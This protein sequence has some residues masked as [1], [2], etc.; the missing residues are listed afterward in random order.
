[1][2]IK[3]SVVLDTNILVSALV[4]GGNPEEILKLALTKKI[5]AVTSLFLLAELTEILSKKFS[6]DEKKTLLVVRKIKNT[7]QVVY[8]K[9]EI[10]V[11]KD[12]NPDNRVLEAAFEGDCSHIITGDKELLALKKF[13]NIKILNAKDFLEKLI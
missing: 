6:F 1:M 11:L 12:N 5:S 3:S 2:S 13:K 8:P 10:T 7:F 9:K 4:F